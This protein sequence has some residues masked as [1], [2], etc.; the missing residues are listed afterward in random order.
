MRFVEST[1]LTP[2]F[3]LCRCGRATGFGKHTDTAVPTCNS[4]SNSLHF[5]TTF[6]GAL[7][8]TVQ[9]PDPTKFSNR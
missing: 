8:T 2:S 4:V 1:I 9:K 7:Y 3:C 5:Q 6:T